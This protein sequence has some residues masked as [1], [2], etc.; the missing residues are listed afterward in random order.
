METVR[1]NWQ[2]LLLLTAL[3]PVALLAVPAV[4]LP[5]TVWSQQIEEVTVTAR[6]REEDKQ[7]VPIA[8]SAFSQDFIEKQGVVNTE[9]VVKLVPGVQFDQGFSAADTR[10][11]IRGINSERGRASVAQLIDG[12][13]ISGENVT[14]GGGGS[15]LNT[16]LLDLERV[17]VIKGPQTALYG[18]NAF[19]GAINYVTVKPDLDAFQLE[20]QADV[21][22]YDTSKIKGAVSLPVIPGVVAVRIGAGAINSGGYYNN[23]IIDSDGDP[24]TPNPAGFDAGNRQDLNGYDNKGARLA[25]LIT[26]SENLEIE[27]AITYSRNESDPRAVAKVSN[28]NTFYDSDGNVL[29]GVTQPEFSAFSNQAY[30]QWLGTVKSISESEIALSNTGA[31]FEFSGSEDKRLLNTLKI[32]W[33]VGAVTLKSLSSYLHN[34]ATL[35]EDAD[36][37]NGFGTVFQGVALSLANDYVDRTDT[38]QLTQDFIVQSNSWERGTWLAGVQYFREEVDND[39]KSLGWYNDPFTAFALPCGTNPGEISCSYEQ[40][41]AGGDPAKNIRRDTD[42]YS[43][44]GLVSYDFT[45]RLT[46]SLELRYVRDEIKVSTN[47]SINRVN[48]YLFHLPPD[49]PGGIPLPQTGENDTS[50]VNPRFTVDYKFTDSAMVFGSVAKGT[51]PGG[52]GTSQMSRPEIAEVDPETLWAYEIGTKTRWLDDSVQANASIF[53]YDYQDRQVGVTVADPEVPN[54]PAAGVAN[55]AK[56]TTKGIELDVLWAPIDYLQLGIGYAYT[57]AEWDDF[58]YSDIRENGPTDKDQAICGNVQGDCSGAD[59]SGIPENAFT[60]LGSWQQPLADYGMDWFLNANAQY[61]SKR[62]LADQVNTPYVDAFWTADAQLGLQTETW[63]VMLFATNIFDDDTVQWGQY[64]QDFKD[65]MY[66]GQFGGEPRDESVMAFLPN[67]RIVGIRGT[68]R[69][70]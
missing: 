49:F 64:Y 40:A 10:I 5:A 8:I 35:S 36:F 15:L 55:A 31:G 61:Q 56:A 20:A 11:S 70:E 50:E 48:Q 57:D 6:R 17:E 14:A 37:Q 13:D 43:A 65:G 26:P 38:D 16:T 23:N 51:K 58:N 68:W 54:F 45:E 44:Y 52:F 12:I 62:S 59:I 66:G 4:L 18:R 27:A 2:K 22:E 24:N 19:A 42:S 69:M 21:A 28:A 29:A 7:D 9:D 25:A 32:N 33:D 60:V 30:G 47:T 53:Y 46:S 67:P 41:L 3:N 39:D 34:D 63:S 1:L